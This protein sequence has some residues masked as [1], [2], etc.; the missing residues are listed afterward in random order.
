MLPSLATAVVLIAN[1]NAGDWA[2]FNANA[3]PGNN[4]DWTNANAD[5]VDW[6]FTALPGNNNNNANPNADMGSHQASTRG[7]SDS[8]ADGG[9]GIGGSGSGSGSE[10]NGLDNFDLG[11]GGFDLCSLVKDAF[12]TCNGVNAGYD[13]ARYACGCVVAAFED[14]NC[15]QLMCASVDSYKK[16]DCQCIEKDGAVCGGPIEKPDVLVN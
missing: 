1:A 5:P 3:S 11:S 2:N 6:G 15:D 4:D 8:H 13:C 12:D 7:D 14:I 10:N 9:L 16:R